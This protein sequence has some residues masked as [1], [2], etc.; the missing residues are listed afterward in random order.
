[1][2]ILENSG[3]PDFGKMCLDELPLAMSYVPMQRWEDLYELSMAL[4]RGTLFAK[5]DLPFIGK[6]AVKN[7]R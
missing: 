2:L 6:E 7:G 3:K 1:M 5:L 4:E